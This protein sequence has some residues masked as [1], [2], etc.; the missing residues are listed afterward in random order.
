MANFY[1]SYAS[2]GGGGGGGGSSSTAPTGDPVPADATYIAGINPAGDLTGVATD[3]AGRLLTGTVETLD[4]TVTGDGNVVDNL[5]V[6][7]YQTI[8]VQI[9]DNQ[10]PLEYTF[11]GSLDG[12][13]YVAAFAWG[14]GGSADATGFQ[15]TGSFQIWT[16]PVTFK[17]LRIGVTNWQGVADQPLTVVLSFADL[18][19][20][21]RIQSLLA[22]FN[23][24]FNTIASNTDNISAA[25]WPSGFGPAATGKRVAAEVGSNGLTNADGN[26]LYIAPYSD[27]V[28][29]Q[30]SAASLSVTLASDQSNLPVSGTVTANAGTGT[31]TTDQ[32]ATQVASFQG[33]AIAFGALTTS[34]ATVMTAGG[35]LRNVM[36]RNN[37]DA[38][39]E[40]SL[41]AGS[42]TSYILD[43]GDAV[44]VDLK[45]LGL[46]IA[47][48]TTLQARYSGSA[49]TLGSIRING[50]SA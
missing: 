17:Y 9:G 24:V 12:V 36:M 28:G 19:D 13:G 46:N 23:S 40:V 6:S 8:Q 43:P 14:S 5:D 15:T 50:V 49:P 35:V 45:P 42:T 47:N 25:N 48:G 30:L 3:A 10:D 11:Y 27:I 29:P 7:L 31:F 21:P 16:I 38:V 44:S 37:T 39:V 32:V 1:A 20:S 22:P 41:D 18:G 4:Y 2:G 26:P 33:G 34:Y